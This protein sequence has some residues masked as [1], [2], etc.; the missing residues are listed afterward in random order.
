MFTKPLRILSMIV[1]FTVS[2]IAAG[3]SLHHSLPASGL[4]QTASETISPPYPPPDVIT[5]PVPTQGLTPV[6]LPS[7]TQAPAS[8][9]Q[10]ALDYIA[11][12]ERIPVEHLFPVNEHRREYG[13]LGRAFW[14][15]KAMD[16]E[17]HQLFTAMV[18]LSSQEPVELEEIELAEN[19]A[20]ETKYGKLEPQL[21]EALQKK[22][23]EDLVDVAI[24]FTPVDFQALL[25]EL[26]AKHPGIS[27]NNI[28]KPWQGITNQELAS[29]VMSDFFQLMGDAHLAKQADLA[30]QLRDQRYGVETQIG[31]PSLVAK[32][33]KRVILEVAQ[34]TDVVRIF[35]LGGEL[36][37]LLDS[38]IPTDRGNTVWQRANQGSG[39]RIAII[40]IGT[41]PMGH[42]SID[43]VAVRNVAPQSDHTAVV[44]SAAA[45]HHATYKGMAP[46]ADVVI[47]AATGGA[48]VPNALYWAI[49]NQAAHIVNA[50]FTLDGVG[51]VND[52]MQWIDRVFDYYA[53]WYRVTMIAAAGNQERG[54][55]ID[56]PAKGYNVLSVGGTTDQNTT[57]GTT[58]QYG[59]IRLPSTVRPGRI[60]SV[61]TAPMETVK[62][63]KL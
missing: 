35:L 47:A 32:L 53:R 39:K 5:G 1:I 57:P 45:S 24:W 13:L 36:S 10:I 19:Q 43:I 33:P 23:Q 54:N 46:E 4:L 60:Q 28:E 58:T 6:P 62:N 18:D 2:T 17:S 61:T 14:Y 30:L 21:Y 59:G 29:Q 20:Q 63:L 11:A 26:Q 9:T 41:V 56:S 25:A 34:R 27:L 7:P 51:N 44:A 37:P 15:V 3:S 8:E 38:A 40:D 52:D 42:P 48:D 49:Y 22:D 55:H 16:L 50:S 31:I 12:R